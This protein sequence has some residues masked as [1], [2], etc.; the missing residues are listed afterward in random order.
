[1]LLRFF[2]VLLIF[3]PSTVLAEISAF[4]NL[5]TLKVYNQSS[6]QNHS[7]KILD[8][9]VLATENL[10]Q[11]QNMP[12]RFIFSIN[13]VNPYILLS[14]PTIEIVTSEKNIAFAETE[15]DGNIVLSL[16]TLSLI[17]NDSELA[18]LLA[19]E[20]GHIFYK[21]SKPSL[22]GFILSN[23]HKSIIEETNKRLELEA[24]EFAKK[25]IEEAGYDSS[26]GAYILTRLN[27]N[28]DKQDSKSE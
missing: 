22:S 15:A 3:Y 9:L 10:I 1:M 4:R 21:H 5:K 6:W 8:K 20:L 28:R 23:F 7:E 16:K 14:P 12:T 13:Q 26:V 27:D 11:G 2:I 19:H 25:V 18:F 17:G 24:D